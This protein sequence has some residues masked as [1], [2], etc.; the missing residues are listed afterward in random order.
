[1]SARVSKFDQQ[2]YLRPNNHY[3]YDY[4]YNNNDEEHYIEPVSIEIE[5]DLSMMEHHNNEVLNNVD[6]NQVIKAVHENELRDKLSGNF[7]Q[8]KY[9]VNHSR[10]VILIDVYHSIINIIIIDRPFMPLI[11]H[12][13]VDDIFIR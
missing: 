5:R 2:F 12:M 3:Y 13:Q 9:Y 10:H 11:Y 4:H 7:K 8:S 6:F 1:M